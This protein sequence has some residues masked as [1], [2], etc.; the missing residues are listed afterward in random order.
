MPRSKTFYLVIEAVA[1]THRQTSNPETQTLNP[2]Q[3]RYSSIEIPR[4]AQN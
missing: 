1:L 3:F 2:N 4:F